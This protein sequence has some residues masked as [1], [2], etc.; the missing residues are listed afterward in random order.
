VNTA[1]NVA[2]IQPKEIAAI[3]PKVIAINPN[4]WS[5]IP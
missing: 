3:E 4:R 5:E 1:T 2:N